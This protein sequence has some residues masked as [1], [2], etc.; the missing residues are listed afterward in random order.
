MHAAQGVAAG[1]P[2][3]A[4]NADRIPEWIAASTQS[5]HDLAFAPIAASFSVEF[6]NGELQFV[7][8]QSCLAEF[9]AGLRAALYRA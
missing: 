2:W 5:R 8:D 1:L 6:I 7:T 9:V 4:L 3:S